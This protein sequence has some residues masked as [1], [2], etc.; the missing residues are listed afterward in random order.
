MEEHNSTHSHPSVN[1][2]T[3]LKDV[4][5]SLEHLHGLVMGE[6]FQYLAGA[7]HG[8]EMTFS[9]L[10]TL[11]RLYRNGPQTVA[12]VAGGA[13]LSPTAASRMVERLVQAGLVERRENKT[14]RRQK[15][16]EV[17]ADG[18][19]RLKDM[20]ATTMAVYSSLLAKAPGETLGK[21]AT[22]LAGLAPY[23]PSH[24]LLLDAEQG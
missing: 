13:D 8:G 17:T 2:T 15:H 16:I 9:Q 19:E 7:L 22:A 1:A 20:Q 18:I 3:G 5:L 12:A 21:L 10:N 11:Y 6:V 4:S 23:L 14:D 24:P